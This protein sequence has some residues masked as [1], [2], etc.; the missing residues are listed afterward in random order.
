V[1]IGLLT[2]SYP[3]FPGD[4]VGGFVAEHAAFLARAGHHVEVIA[5]GTEREAPGPDAI[6]GLMGQSCASGC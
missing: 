2:T 6:A 1:R 5:G 3:Q 4:R